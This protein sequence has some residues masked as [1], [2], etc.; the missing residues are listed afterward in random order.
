[1]RVA[2]PPAEARRLSMRLSRGGILAEPDD[3]ISR[4]DVL[5]AVEPKGDLSAYRGRVEWLVVLGAP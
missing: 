5:V 2:A 4:A 3:G 1:M